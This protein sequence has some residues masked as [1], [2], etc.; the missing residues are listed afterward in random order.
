MLMYLKMSRIAPADIVRNDSPGK[1]S[2]SNVSHL[3]TN[4]RG[5]GG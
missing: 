3:V 1:G 5:K 4:G 2:N